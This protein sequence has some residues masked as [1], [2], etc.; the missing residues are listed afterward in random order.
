MTGGNMSNC[1]DC[2]KCEGY[3][4]IATLSGFLVCNNFKQKEKEMEKQKFQFESEEQIREFISNCIIVKQQG[5]TFEIEINR[6][7]ELAR[8]AGYIRKTELQTLQE[9]YKKMIERYSIIPDDLK[10][11]SDYINILESRNDFDCEK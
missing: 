6:V 5:S 2:C 7:I 1:N 4:P 8:L 3:Q 11:A 10:V 9:K